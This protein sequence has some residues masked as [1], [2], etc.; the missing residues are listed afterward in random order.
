MAA[1]P[2]KEEGSDQERERARERE[3]E[4]EKER[5]RY[6]KGRGSAGVGDSRTATRASDMPW[7]GIKAAI[8]L[9][10]MRQ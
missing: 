4:R 8:K 10:S 5:S 6:A 7:H 9:V 3:S 1:V 2:T